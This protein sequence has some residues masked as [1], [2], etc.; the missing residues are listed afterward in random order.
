MT[1]ITNKEKEVIQVIREY[2]KKVKKSIQLL[3]IKSEQDKGFQARDRT[4]Y[5]DEKNK[6]KYTFHGY[7]CKINGDEFIVDFNIM[8][9]RRC[10]GFQAHFVASFLI[11][12]QYILRYS[13]NELSEV[14]N[15]F[16]VF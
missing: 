11:D 6:I 5:L 7:G 2:L 16:G 4:G 14:F 1:E 9:N 13:S 10:D 15:Q 8:S 12:N 3:N